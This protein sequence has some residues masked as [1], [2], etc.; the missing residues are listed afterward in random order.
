[1]SRRVI[2][3]KLDTSLCRVKRIFDDIKFHHLLVIGDEMLFG[4]IS[5]RDLLKNISPYIGTEAETDRDRQTLRKTA[6][7]I[8]TRKPVVLTRDDGIY[9]AVDVFTEYNISCIP[10][11]DNVTNMKPVGL[12]SW[13]DIMNAIAQKRKK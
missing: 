4:V 13:R 1:M 2:T 9:D 7:Q 10:I 3:V 11:V 12:I 5:D 8:M 6:H